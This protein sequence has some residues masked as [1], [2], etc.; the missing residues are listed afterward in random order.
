MEYAQLGNTGR[1]VSRIGFGGA[2]AGLKNYLSDFDPERGADREAILEAIHEAL[3][4][5]IN[6]FDTAAGYGDGQ[7]ESL[8]GEGL[9]GAKPEEVF[10][11]T[12]AGVWKDEPLRASLESSLKRLRRDRVDLLQLHGTVYTPEHCERIL[13][14][15][16]LLDQLYELKREGLT[17]FVGFSVEALNRPLFDLL[18]TERFDV[19]QIAYNFIF[20]HPY[21][22][23]WKSGALYDA[24]AKGMGIVA[25]RSLTSGIF[26]RWIQQVNPANDFDYAEPLIQ[27]QL[28]NP[29]V[30]V[31]L[32]GMRSKEEVRKNAAI[33][34]D[35]GGR[36]DLGRL[37][38]RYV[39]KNPIR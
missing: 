7:S 39:G 10:L 20:Q 31:A 34:A 15:G 5:G 3:G 38:Q 24:E 30:D 16:G 2:T 37:Y 32:L 21:D 35:L 12:K 1:N 28:S 25:M 9:A 8:F 23:S 19:A 29:L 26:Q 6:Y 22:P 11:A 27:F 18:D 17:R 4:L 13:K 14:S 36:I 33:A